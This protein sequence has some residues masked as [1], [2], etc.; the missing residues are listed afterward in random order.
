MT[1]PT[2]DSSV[3]AHFSDA[4][5]PYLGALMAKA[6]ARKIAE[7]PV[8]GVIRLVDRREPSAG[9]DKE[10]V[11][12]FRMITAEIPDADQSETV[13]EVERALFLARTATGTITED[14]DIRLAKQTL[15]TAG[16][17][18]SHIAAARLR[19]GIDQ[20]AKAARTATTSRL[21][22]DEMWREMERLADG[23]DT[24]LGRGPA[25]DDDEQLTL[26]DV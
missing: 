18:V 7:V 10:P 17:L 1:K 4:L 13:R 14:G 24:L 9:E 6:R 16:G 22:A 25:G 8:V 21:S 19:A 5:A 2:F 20:W 12:K 23:L 26:D 15:Q 3:T 11:A